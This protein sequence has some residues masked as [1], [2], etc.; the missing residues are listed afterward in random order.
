MCIQYTY[1][2]PINYTLCNV[3]MVSHKVNRDQNLGEHKLHLNTE[4][5]IFRSNNYF[6]LAEPS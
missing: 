3:F 4:T 2:I 6:N 5:Q 1:F